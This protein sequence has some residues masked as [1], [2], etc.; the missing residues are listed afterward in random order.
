MTCILGIDPGSRVTGFG[1]IEW[2]RQKAYFRECG[3]IRLTAET[4]P[5]RLQEIF[6]GI[7]E[8]I[9]RQAPD[10]LAIEQVFMSHNANSALKLGQARGV[11]IVAGVLRGLSIAE[12]APTQIKQAI[13]G[14]GHA[15]KIQ[16]QHMI[17]ILL[18]LSDTPQ[19]DAADALA[20]ALCHAHT[21][22]YTQRLQGSRF[23]LK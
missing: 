15:D 20:V 5:E 22:R 9:T 3:C 8:V 11:A 10:V 2:V 7:T 16:V 12:Y 13:T 1:V 6:L 17:K 18:N 23:D 21:A 4:L 14:Q 19:A